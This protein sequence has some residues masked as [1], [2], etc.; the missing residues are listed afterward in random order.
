MLFA[1]VLAISVAVI[2]SL[3]EARAVPTYQPVGYTLLYT[4]LKALPN[5]NKI[6]RPFASATE[7]DTPFTCAA[8]C[9]S[10]PSCKFFAIYTPMGSKDRAC[11]YYQ[12]EDPYNENNPSGTQFTHQVRELC[13]YQ[14]EK[15]DDSKSKTVE[16]SAV[17]SPDAQKRQIHSSPSL[18]VRYEKTPP[19]PPTP[20]RNCTKSTVGKPEKR[21]TPNLIP[22][23]PDTV[24]EETVKR[25]GAIRKS[26]LAVRSLLN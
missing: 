23:Y 13:G 11:Q 9:D 15:D 12:E 2:A 5:S 26:L 17:E 24:A 6:I 4:G 8:T 21:Y 18:N 16:N 22:Y 25:C 19:P 3:S 7:P 20:F 10:I 1:P 14:R